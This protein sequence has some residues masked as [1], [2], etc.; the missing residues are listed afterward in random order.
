MD[1]GYFFICKIG[2]VD[3]LLN[4]FGFF[5]PPPTE[6]SCDMF[7]TLIVYKYRNFTRQRDIS[8][9]GNVRDF[10]SHIE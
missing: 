5:F 7:L 9:G 1:H 4:I 6:I 2:K 3:R 10:R 8:E